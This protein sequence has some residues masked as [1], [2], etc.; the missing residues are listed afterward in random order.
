MG[1]WNLVQKET[2]T[3]GSRIVQKWN[4]KS[5]EILWKSLN[6]DTHYMGKYVKVFLCAHNKLLELYNYSLNKQA[7]VNFQKAPA[8]F[9]NSGWSP[10]KLSIAALLK[11]LFAF[12]Y[13]PNA[14]LLNRYIITMKSN[15]F[16]KANHI[17][18]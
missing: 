15:S 16:F 3:I 10:W 17:Y 6:L 2:Q 13:S 1:S 8:L 18:T 14:S 4:L 7:K 11:N 12:N 5:S 9:A